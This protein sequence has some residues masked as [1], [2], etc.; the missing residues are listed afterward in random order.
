[1]TIEM[2]MMLNQFIEANA[3][4][5]TMH[6]VMSDLHDVEAC[7]RV[8]NAYRERGM[9][10]CARISQEHLEEA[11]E[12]CSRTLRRAGIEYT[13]EDLINL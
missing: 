7:Q 10:D 8:V 13:T 11:K 4:V 5:T 6:E 1:M 2:Q 12:E 9:H 3:S